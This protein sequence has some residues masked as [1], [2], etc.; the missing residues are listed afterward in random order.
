VRKVLHAT[1]LQRCELASLP[2]E[3]GLA[4]VIRAQWGRPIE[5]GVFIER[6][7][8][9]ELPDG[10]VVTLAFDVLQTRMWSDTHVY[11]QTGLAVTHLPDSAVPV[12]LVRTDTGFATEVTYPGVVVGTVRVTAPR[13]TA[14]TLTA[15]VGMTR[16]DAPEA[17]R[18]AASKYVGT[19][20]TVALQSDAGVVPLGWTFAATCPER[21]TP[22]GV[23]ITR[24]GWATIFDRG[25]NQVVPVRP[26]AL[27][28]SL[29][30]WLIRPALIRGG[31]TN[32]AVEIGT[33]ERH[34]TCWVTAIEGAEQALWGR[35]CADGTVQIRPR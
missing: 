17:A 10:T 8:V 11:E 13:K 15:S 23:R 16:Q 18:Q 2:Y 21:A 25:M 35:V 28:Q 32:N 14:G 9:A 7:V 20:C 26:V 34:D 3:S 4:R 24:S 29:A 1:R 12:T 31:W 5:P 22:L 6:G 27:E 30:M 19:P 33:I